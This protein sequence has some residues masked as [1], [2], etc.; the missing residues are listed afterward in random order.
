MFLKII[1]SARWTAKQEKSEIF[2]SQFLEAITMCFGLST[3]V[4]GRSGNER[5]SL[6]GCLRFFIGGLSE[7][8]A[9][10]LLARFGGPGAILRLYY[11]AIFV[12]FKKYTSQ[13][14][15]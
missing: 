8:G 14:S 10:R 2:F 3:A 11:N 5:S 1:L 7:S 9:N 4:A 15:L 13:K 12:L 6:W